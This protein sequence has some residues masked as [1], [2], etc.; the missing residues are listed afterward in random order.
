MAQRVQYEVH[1]K[2]KLYFTLKVLFS[3]IIYTILAIALI[4]ALSTPQGSIA[5]TGVLFY[6]ILIIIGILFSIGLLIGHLKGNAVKITADQF[7]DIYEIVRKQSEALKL[8]AVP[9]AYIL[10]S[11]GLLNAFAT[12][13]LGR[14]YIV[15]YS[16]ILEEAYENNI[17][18]VEFV[19]AHELGHVERNH[20]TK[21]MLLFPS[22]LVP[23]LQPAYSRGCEY[24]CDRIGAALSPKGAV[25]G[26]SVLAAGKKL[27]KK[28][29]VDAYVAQNRTEAG[30]WP[31]IAEKLSTHPKL[32]KRVAE[33]A[34][35]P[36]FAPAAKPASKEEVKEHVSNDHTKYMPGI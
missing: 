36:E 20:I 30:F 32:T 10:Q 16:E 11:G 7:P 8:S 22:A 17:E 6:V 35:R 25:T 1:P 4:G 33:F 15:I 26:L 31:W 9:Q 5:A 23:F 13:F 21:N 28:V 24:T 2:E 14:N 12:K 29:N 3:G 19:I 34:N 27:Y 18:A